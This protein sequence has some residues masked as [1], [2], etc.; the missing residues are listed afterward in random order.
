MQVPES[1]GGHPGNAGSEDELRKFR[2]G[3]G[4][5]AV[6][7]LVAGLYARFDYPLTLPAKPPPPPP[8]DK[9]AL[10][11]MDFENPDIYKGYLEQDSSTYRVGRT[12]PEDL[13][14]PFAYEK[15]EAPQELTPGGPA[16]ETG[17]LRVTARVQKL[18]MRTRKGSA[19]AEHFI[20]RIQNKR[21]RP[22]AYRVQTSF[23]PGGDESCSKKAP[24]EHNAIAIPA[25]GSIERSEC[26]YRARMT[27]SVQA[28]EAM[29]LPALSYFYVSRLYPP[30]IGTNERTSANHQAPAGSACATVPQQS[31]LI[32]M[33]K[34][35]VSWR[36]VVDF[37]AR[38]R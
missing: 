33:E 19:A 15:S 17:M 27:I 24:L 26:F 22:V 1:D 32:G 3:V 9:A 5:G 2:I 23:G 10:R 35:T 38:H 36:D 28:V 30:H 13:A 20:V 37:Y 18:E 16:V 4:V 21:N 11:R 31:I 25:G 8:P 34:G 7:V 29:E 12:A 6:V 14:A